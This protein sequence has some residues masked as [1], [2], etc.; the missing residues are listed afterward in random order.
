MNVI[1]NA[2]DIPTARGKN[3]APPSP[4]TSPTRA[5]LSANFALRAAI[6]MSHIVAKS[7]PAPIAAPFT[8]AMMGASRL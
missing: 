1:S 8:A 6:R 3:Q 2:L 4:E 5:K 7:K